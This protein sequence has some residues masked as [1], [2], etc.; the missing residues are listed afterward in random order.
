MHHVHYYITLKEH[1]SLMVILAVQTS[2]IIMLRVVLAYIHIA[3]TV[4]AQYPLTFDWS[5]KL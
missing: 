1:F 4:R 2:S 5:F 3:S